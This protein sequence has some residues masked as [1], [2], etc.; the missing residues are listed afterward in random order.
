MFDLDS[1]WWAFNNIYLYIG[2]SLTPARLIP[3]VRSPIVTWA[4]GLAEALQEVNVF[5]LLLQTK[6]PSVHTHIH[7]HI[8][9]HTHT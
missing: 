7:T 6:H 8:C 4:L 2:C 9:I 1:T 5:L 3:T